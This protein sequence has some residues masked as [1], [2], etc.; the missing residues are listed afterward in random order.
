MKECVESLLIFRPQ[1]W[2]SAAVSTVSLDSNIE[3]LTLRPLVKS[4]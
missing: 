3:G 4:E 1:E 2:F